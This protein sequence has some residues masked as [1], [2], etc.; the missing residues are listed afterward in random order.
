MTNPSTIKSEL[1]ALE[2]RVEVALEAASAGRNAAPEALRELLI[3]A[4]AYLRS[5]EA[6]SEQQ[7]SAV[8]S[9][10]RALAAL[11]AWH[12]WRPPARPTA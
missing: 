3:D 10:E 7:P 9:V 1:R 5:L 2:A 6:A 12:R 11:E 8:E 4:L